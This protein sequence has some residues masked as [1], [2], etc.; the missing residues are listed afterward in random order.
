MLG[1]DTRSSQKN[2]LSH[3]S[4]ESTPT[5]SK[6][7]R[8]L[9]ALSTQLAGYAQLAE[10]LQAQL[11]ELRQEQTELRRTAREQQALIETLSHQANM[12][13]HSGLGVTP[14]KL[15]I[16]GERE[17]RL[18]REESIQ[19]SVYDLKLTVE[20]LRRSLPGADTTRQ[21]PEAEKELGYLRAV[22]QIREAVRSKVPYDATVVV[23]NDGDSQL[24]DL[25]GRA[26]WHFPQAQDGS[27]AA[28]YPPNS[29]SAIIQLEVLRAKG[30]DF[31]IL[32]N[33]SLSLEKYDDFKRHAQRRYQVAHRDDACMIF[34]LREL[35]VAHEISMWGEFERVISD[36]QGQV[37]RNPTILDWNTG[38]GLVS[39][40]PEHTIF[41][42]HGADEVL[43]Y[44]DG[45]IDI[46]V[47]PSNQEAL[48]AEAHRVAATAVVTAMGTLNSAQSGVTFDVE[49]K[50]VATASASAV[51]SIIIPSHNSLASL[52][53]CWR[54]LQ[55]T[56]PSNF[57][58]EI[59]FIDDASDDGTEYVMEKWRAQDSR[60]RV[61]SNSSRAGF[62]T[63]CN[64][65]ARAATGEILVF[66]D[67]DT[68][69]LS[70]WLP[71]LVRTF[72]THANAGV[73]G[74]KLLYPDGALK[75]AGASIFHDGS[76]ARPGS[77][78][79]N[80]DA[81]LYSYVR[82]ADFCSSTLFATSRSLFLELGGFD[83]RYE[84]TPYTHADYCLAA[85]KKGYKVYYQPESAAI[86]AEQTEEAQMPFLASPGS[87]QETGA[88]PELPG[89]KRLLTRW[90][91]ALKRF[92]PRPRK[93]DMMTCMTLPGRAEEGVGS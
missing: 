39:A 86:Q 65:G 19:E 50:P 36:F 64:Q 83:S 30:G 28:E 53:V 21:D 85:R 55:D 12:L 29:S 87:A 13:P 88:Q 44:L 25:Y 32:P 52:Q 27:D 3:S 35:P 92:P 9:K 54:A 81:P 77:G 31:L 7:R 43:P 42:P 89:Q 70:G 33:T 34:A 73:V 59:I 84:Q 57:A 17:A 69:P 91:A 63:A 76:I 20:V 41:S 14:Q 2:G 10:S 18:R 22:R 48:R 68:I 80:I 6:A 90:R 75:E 93:L 74:G 61:L 8:D 47:I 66:L 67:V 5:Q 71:S 62:A 58:G 56:L 78:D 40:F 45:S 4:R 23:A 46:V 1:E 49:W 16:V 79:F 24:L 60:V 26:A 82:E 72:Q 37:D 38:L 15:D 11:E 51:A